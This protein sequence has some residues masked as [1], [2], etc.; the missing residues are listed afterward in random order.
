MTPEQDDDGGDDDEEEDKEG[1]DEAIGEEEE[2][3]P[4]VQELQNI[5][6]LCASTSDDNR[7]ILSVR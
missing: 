5:S 2:V 3:E 1:E 6:H 7:W 4:F